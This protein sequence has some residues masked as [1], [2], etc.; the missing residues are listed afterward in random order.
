MEKIVSINGGQNEVALISFL[1]DGLTTRE[2]DSALGHDA[3]T[4]KGWKSFKILKK[5]H[6]INSD[7]GRLFCCASLAEARAVVKELMTCQDRAGVE[8]VL[9]SWKP[10]ILEPFEG[11]QI[12][13]PSPQALT[14]ALSGEGRNLV[15]RFFSRRKV[16]LGHCQ[17]PGCQ[18]TDRLDTVHLRERRTVK[19]E[20]AARSAQSTDGESRFDLYKLMRAFLESHLPPGEI[21]FMCKAHHIEIHKLEKSEPDKYLKFVKSLA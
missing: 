7:K 5:H 13:A 9:S 11:I 20:Q 10:R 18:E 1:K 6:L 15:Q 17:F 21:A 2:I 3:T 12:I 4:T 19:L 8:A 14:K 16:I